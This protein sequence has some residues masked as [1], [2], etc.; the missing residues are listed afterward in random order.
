MNSSRRTDQR[1]GASHAKSAAVSTRAE[2]PSF[3]RV[4]S[5]PRFAANRGALPTRLNE[6]MPN[7]GKRLLP[8]CCMIAN[9]R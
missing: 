7:Y 6:I 1:P 8:R 2:V 5:G 4:P 3:N 9:P